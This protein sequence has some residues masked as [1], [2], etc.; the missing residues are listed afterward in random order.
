MEF[1]EIM[2]NSILKSFASYTLLLIGLL[3]TCSYTSAQMRIG[4]N[5]D[6]LLLLLRKSGADTTRVEI[7][8]TLGQQYESNL[9]DSALH[10]YALAGSLSRRIN[11]PVGILKY[12]S[13][14]TAV[15]NVQGKLEESIKLNLEAVRIGTKNHLTLQAA[16]AYV[17]L[18]A[19]YQYKEDFPKAVEY[20]LKA[21]PLIEK[22]GMPQAHS[23]LL[24][25]LCGV[26]RSINQPEKAI[27]YAKQALL[28]SEKSNDIISQGQSYNSLGNCFKDGGDN[29]QAEFYYRKAEALAVST[30]DL[31]L[32]ET[33][34]INLGNVYLSLNL[35]E[36]SI[37]FFDRALPLTDSIND[38]SGK[39]YVLLGIGEGLY[40]MRRWPEAESQLKQ[41][42][43]FARDHD[44]RDILQELYQVLSDVYI[45]T[46][47]FE[48]AGR[49]R[50]LQDSVEQSIMD[51]TILQ[52]V[53]S[54]EAE[55]R[56]QQKQNELLT[57]D[58]EL[59]HSKAATMQQRYWLVASY[60]GVA[61]LVLVLVVTYVFFRQ[62]QL[63]NKQTI[64]TLEVDKKNIRL[65]AL[66]EGQHQERVRISQEIHDDM[67]SGLTSILFISRSLSSSSA[68][69]SSV[70]KLTLLSTSLIEKMNE[71][72][73]AMR[74]E[75]ELVEDFALHLRSLAG[76]LLGNAGIDVE[77]RM[78]ELVPQVVLT[79]EYRHPIYLIVKE[80]I[81]NILKHSRATKVMISL[82]FASSW[83][84]AISDN[85]IGMGGDDPKNISGNGL[86]N[87]R[88]RIASIGGYI[89]IA[90]ENGTTVLLEIPFVM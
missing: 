42:I 87:M 1:S 30:S 74:G 55:Y 57:K 71:I 58:L 5:K 32:Q 12:I 2:E 89:S 41:A 16:K 29:K 18:G 7:Y 43:L 20:Y 90:S 34:L 23:L 69:V 6:S 70:S 3:L 72:V 26:Y 47:R 88:K 63:I 9:P 50:K 14:Y 64:E 66:L 83:T 4:L 84:I 13:N 60:S 80:A 86:R 28:I 78:S 38:V 67:G 79:T 73:W 22:S 17:N 51:T 39:A 56:L 53:Q 46:H 24:N 33:A 48:Q 10:Y 19:V 44:Q 85:G 82:R 25:N 54:L 52:S 8:I 31:N 37:T 36:K 49:T 61:V 68:D 40:K 21:L 11:Y 65:Q 81:H 62:R 76:D 27:D 75:P 45:A 77:F 15:L 59:Q 35:P